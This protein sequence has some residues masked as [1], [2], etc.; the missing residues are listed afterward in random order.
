MPAA[1]GATPRKM[2]P[3]PMT[4]PI[5][6]PRRDTCATSAT[7]FSIVWRLMPNGSS[8]IRASPDSLRRIRLY[9]G[10]TATASMRFAGLCH[11]LGSEVTAFLFDAFADDE[12]RIGVH[13]RL[14][15]RQHFFHGLLIV[16][17]ERLAEQRLLA[18]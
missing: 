2:L 7:M 18:E 1:P 11:D 13:F 12:E 6:T 15:R 10:V 17:D 5:S 4:T 9:L 16:L 8:P 3:P 14:S